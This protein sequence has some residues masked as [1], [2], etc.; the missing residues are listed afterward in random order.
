MNEV[1]GLARKKVEKSSEILFAGRGCQILDNVELDVAVTQ[2]LQ[3]AVRLASVGIVVDR[4][5]VHS[6]SPLCGVE[7][8][9]G[10]SV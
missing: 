10:I 3:R 9:T 8:A 7:R 4:D 6:R 1:L 5:L 2:D